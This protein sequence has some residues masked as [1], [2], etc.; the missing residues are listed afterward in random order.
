MK[1]NGSS[2]TSTAEELE[3]A[4]QAQR[5]LFLFD[6]GGVIVDSPLEE[7]VQEVRVRQKCR[8]KVAFQQALALLGRVKADWE[9]LERGEINTLVEFL[10]GVHPAGS[11]PIEIDGA[12][13]KGESDTE[14]KHD[15]SQ[16]NSQSAEEDRGILEGWLRRLGKLQPHPQVLWMIAMLKHFFN[17]EIGI[18]TNNFHGIGN[19]MSSD[20]SD[21][22][23]NAQEALSNRCSTNRNLP[24]RSGSPTEKKIIELMRD[25]IDGTSSLVDFVVESYIEGCRKGDPAPHDCKIFEIALQRSRFLGKP[26][27]V[28][29]GNT[30]TDRVFFFDD[31]KGNL[32]AP[33]E[34]IGISCYHTVGPLKLVSTIVSQVFPSLAAKIGLRHP[35]LPVPDIVPFRPSQKIDLKAVETYLSA[36]LKK[37]ATGGHHGST[38]VARSE[39]QIQCWKSDVEGFDAVDDEVEV[40]YAAQF[41]FGQSNPTY[42]L[43]VRKRKRKPLGR[44]QE[45]ATFATNS[46]HKN[47]TPLI[48]TDSEEWLAKYCLVLRKQPPG[49]LLPKAHDMA[50]E[51]SVMRALGE[52]TDVPV[53]KVLVLEKTPFEGGS[54]IIANANMKGAT[55]KASSV[56]NPASSGLKKAESPPSSP[57]KRVHFSHILVDPQPETQPGQQGAET[58]VPLLATNP[59]G[60]AFFVMRY[61]PG[62]VFK[63]ERLPDLRCP[64]RRRALYFNAVDV[65]RKIHNVPY[66]QDPELAKLLGSGRDYSARQ[67][68]VWAKQYAKANGKLPSM[69]RLEGTLLSPEDGVVAVENRFF[70]VRK[71]L[72]ASEKVQVQ[73]VDSACLVHGDFRLNNLI[74]CPRT[75]CIRAVVDWELCTAGLPLVDLASMLAPFPFGTRFAGLPLIDFSPPIDHSEH[76]CA[77][78]P[79]L[80]ELFSHYQQSEASSS[81]SS[82]AGA[83]KI[84]SSDLRRVWSLQFFRLAGILQGVLDRRSR[85]AGAGRVEQKGL[86]SPDAIAML[87]DEAEKILVDD[88]DDAKNADV[89]AEDKQQSKNIERRSKL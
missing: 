27:A 12:K 8:R 58:A 69:Q 39:K 41:A 46:V 85:G 18:V 80:G 11:M 3:S 31:M 35:V 56:A 65:L 64:A 14:D 66:A 10:D 45:Q 32:V 43:Y 82:T 42:F 68:K 87:A 4:S 54:D 75:M 51:F 63:S 34:K 40:K 15:K 77:G 13:K 78:I 81:S 53:P 23:K 1:M 29:T 79:T 28:G 73:Q 25:P 89:L 30:S 21:G 74:V 17:F 48:D 71:L 50:R 57:T 36:L 59:V 47:L 22:E 38:T 26:E 76:A 20:D 61:M 5:A 24:P 16:E 7:L 19:A 9:R 44:D 6:F 62:V 72:Q 60:T 55:S 52:R 84:S 88:E 49:K 2:K 86:F 70:A 33:A 67:V 83:S 37:S